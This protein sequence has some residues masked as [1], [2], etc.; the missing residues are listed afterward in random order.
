M[1]GCVRARLPECAAACVGGAAACCKAR[2]R[3]DCS[4]TPQMPVAAPRPHPRSR[5]RALCAVSCSWQRAYSFCFQTACFTSDGVNRAV[6][7]VTAAEYP[8]TPA[9]R[10][11]PRVPV[12]TLS[13]LRRSLRLPTASEA[14]ASP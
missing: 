2:S 3:L 9:Y 14:S 1:R 5:L 8:S 4:Q 10:G 6:D 11:V 12:S 13:T 7:T